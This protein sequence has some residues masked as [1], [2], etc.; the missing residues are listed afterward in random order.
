MKPLPLAIPCRSSSTTRCRTVLLG[1]MLLG[2]GLL[3]W[4]G[5]GGKSA[6]PSP[7]LHVV[8]SIPPLAAWI[9]AVGGSEVVVTTL[10]P[11]GSNPHTFDLT[12]AQLLAVGKADLLVLNGAGLEPWAERIRQNAPSSLRTLSLTDG[13]TLLSDHHADHG[14][15]GNPH[16]WLDPLFAHDAVLRL[17]AVLDS[18]RPGSS[19]TTRA[20]AYAD[21]LLALDRWIRAQL[22]QE[23]MT[24]ITFHASWEYF[25]KRYGITIAGSIESQPGRELSPGELSSLI[26]LIRTRRIPLLVTEPQFPR[27]S[28]DVLAQETGIRVIT[29]DAL[30]G[31][32]DNYFALMRNNVE[33]LVKGL[34]P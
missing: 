32:S 17:G 21:S 29:L 26:A 13:A 33:V 2:F 8:T 27:R 4:S 31:T 1:L 18:L 5:C 3:S 11:A 22:P 24:V 19:F 16:L 34:R 7:T 30:G 25:A 9:T 6:A 12:P 10:V 15:F 23:P 28:C 20:K 14:T